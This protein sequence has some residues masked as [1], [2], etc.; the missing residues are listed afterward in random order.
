[1]FTKLK[2]FWKLNVQPTSDGVPVGKVGS[3][4]TCLCCPISALPDKPAAADIKEASPTMVVLSVAPPID[5]GGVP[6]YGYR[7]SYDSHIQDFRI[8][9]QPDKTD[10]YGTVLQIR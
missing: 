3:I 5:D 7:V 8:G 10:M 2:I 6:V 1:M 4:S 9:R